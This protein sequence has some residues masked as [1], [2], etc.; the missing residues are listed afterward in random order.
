MKTEKNV[1]EL[2]SDECQRQDELWGI[3]N[4]H[5]LVWMTILQEEIGEVAN[6]ICE[7]DFDV[8]KMNLVNYKTELVQCAAVIQQMIKNIEGYNQNG[9]K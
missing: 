9:G 3:R 1:T 7:G 2:I 4:Q 6:E 8:S 5:P